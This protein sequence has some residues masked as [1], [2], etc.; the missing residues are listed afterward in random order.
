MNQATYLEDASAI[1]PWVSFLKSNEKP[2]PLRWLWDESAQQSG[3]APFGAQVWSRSKLYATMTGMGIQCGKHGKVAVIEAQDA[4]ELIICLTRFNGNPAEYQKIK[5]TKAVVASGR[6]Q[7]KKQSGE[8]GL[9]AVAGPGASK[10][11]K[12][13]ES[14]ESLAW[15][16]DQ[17]IPVKT[18]ALAEALGYQDTGSITERGNSFVAMGFVFERNGSF[19]GELVWTVGRV[20]NPTGRVHAL[21]PGRSEQA[22][23]VGFAQACLSP[24]LGSVALPRFGLFP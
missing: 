15:F 10:L 20:M 22:R 24:N 11:F 18:S 23:S 4:A 8:S 14:A 21:P 5:K 19:Q 12:W 9:L 6:I 2:F 16:A 13:K 3:E 7:A 17:G 1:E